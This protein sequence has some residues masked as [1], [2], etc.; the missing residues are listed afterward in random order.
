MLKRD[1]ASKAVIRI[2]TKAGNG[3][4]FFVIKDDILYIV[5]ARHITESIDFQTKIQIMGTDRYVLDIE[6]DSLE[7]SPIIISH[8]NADIGVI[9]IDKTVF[10]PIYT[11]AIFFDYNTMLFLDR[12]SNIS[13]DTEMTCIGFP[14]D[15]GCYGTFEPLTFRS[16]PA[17]NLIRNYHLDYTEFH[18]YQDIFI[19]ENPS[20]CGYSGGPI[21]DL[22]YKVDGAIKQS[23]DTI[24][25]GV[26]SGTS[27]DNTGGKMALV[28]PVYYL[29]DI[30]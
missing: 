12:N 10:N 23:S 13:R 17:S 28:T 21:I 20:C 19:L 5:T 22:G 8:P 25:Y 3:T 26:M 2:I 1:D 27:N 29:A 11:S 24:I 7:Q 30:I 4:G 18:F 15:F 16:H 9:R 6:F 14:K